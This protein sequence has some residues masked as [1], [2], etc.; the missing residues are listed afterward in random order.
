MILAVAAL[1]ACWSVTAHAQFMKLPGASTIAIKSGETIE[2]GQVYWVDQC[3]SILKSLPEVEVLD[4]PEQI[5]ASIREAM[6]LP[7]WMGC[8]KKIAGGVLVISAKDIEDP[9]FTRLTL[10][11]KYDTK[12]GVRKYSRVFNLQLVP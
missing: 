1:A 2:L 8:A 7:R 10:R 4:G 9:S 12:D 6:V 5:S 3:R 11:I